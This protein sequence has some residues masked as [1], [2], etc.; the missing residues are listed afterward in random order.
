M[1]FEAIGI[2]LLYR[3]YCFLQEMNLAQWSL[4]AAA[5]IPFVVRAPQA[6]TPED[7][8]LPDVSAAVALW[9][10]MCGLLAL[11]PPAALWIQALQTMVLLCAAVLIRWM[12]FQR[13]RQ[14]RLALE[15]AALHQTETAAEQYMQVIRTQRNDLNISIHTIAGLL[16]SGKA[17]ECMAYVDQL[18]GDVEHTNLAMG[19][20]DPAIGAMLMEYIE[21]ANRQKIQLDVSISDDLS[22]VLCTPYEMNRVI[23][24]LLQNALEAVREQPEPQI[25]FQVF[26]RGGCCNV[27]TINAYAEDAAALEKLFDANYTTKQK[28]DGIGLENVRRIARR[29]GGSVLAQLIGGNLEVIVRIPERV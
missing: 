25:Q 27:K 22:G 23:G 29:Y 28:H 21:S 8:M 9:L 11:A 1:G 6:V 3:G 14:Q 26:K 5:L 7:R 4:L 2:C 16:S 24:N 13:V 20:K 17:A 10:G 18:T 15:N 19:V 12:L